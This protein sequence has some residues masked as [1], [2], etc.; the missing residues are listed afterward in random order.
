MTKRIV[1]LI[2]VFLNLATIF[3][4]SHQSG[5]QSGALSDGISRQIELRTSQYETKNQGEKN[6]LHVKVQKRVRSLAHEFLFFLLGVWMIWWLV[7]KPIRWYGVTGSLLFG[8]FCA[9]GDEFHQMFVPGRT[10]QWKDVQ[11]D[12]YGY[13]CGVFVVFL[14]VLIR[15]GIKALKRKKV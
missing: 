7:L 5:K 4:F 6:A 12:L 11:Y 13:F 10:A 14:V 2:L 3:F 1:L 9:L 15:Y 8:V